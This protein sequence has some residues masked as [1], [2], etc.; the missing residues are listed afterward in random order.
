M[1][2]PAFLHPFAK[3]SKP[4]ADFIKLV[5]GKGSTLWDEAGNRYLDGMASLWY[6][7]AGYGEPRIIDA[8]KSQLD[9]LVVYN[10]FDPWTNEPTEALAERIASVAPFPDARVFFGGS[11]SEAVDT[12]LKLAR[13]AQLRRGQPHKQIL[14]SREGGY[15]GTN[16]GGTSVQGI[17]A[18]REGW[19]ELVG[20]VSTVPGD[21]IEAASRLFASQGDRI[22]AVIAEPVQGAGGVN[23]PPEGYLAGLRRLCDDHGAFLI[24]D[25]VICGWGRLGEWFG[26][27]HYGVTP[28]LITFAKG[29]TSGYQPLGGVVVAPS[30]HEPLSADPDFL[31]RHGYTYS[32]HPTCTAAGLAT[33]EV[34]EQDELFARSEAIG[35]LLTDG[36]ASLAA[37]GIIA[38][39]RGAGAVWAAVLEPGRDP[40]AVRDRMLADGVISRPLADAMAF[41]PPLVMTDAEVTR[42]VDALARALG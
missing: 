39:Y 20:G 40:Y 28:D 42:C 41:C 3:P 31:L 5:G 36:L 29:V 14:V 22:A 33:L 21:D 35:K 26:C 34:Y 19:G 6:C 7:N 17:V 9:R 38:G 11:G 24:V 4:A 37:D 32:G 2:A 23:P 10:T 13:A 8:V 18:N 16:Y 27:Q 15:H 12:A 1:A 25:E 30:V